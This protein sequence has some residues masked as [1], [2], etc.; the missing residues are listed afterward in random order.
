MPFGMAWTEALLLDA[1]SKDDFDA[2]GMAE[3]LKA[4][5]C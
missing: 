3:R 5:V 1:V 4:A 2:G